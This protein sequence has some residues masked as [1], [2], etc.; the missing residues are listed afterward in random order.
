MEH[1]P[2][3]LRQLFEGALEPDELFTALMP[4]LGE[5]L[6]CDRSF[7]YLREPVKQHGIIT[8]CWAR[9]GRQRTGWVPMAGRYECTARS[10]HDDR[11]A[12]PYC[13]VCG[14]Y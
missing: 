11:P 7:L 6:P 3:G 9:D 12:Y 10:T 14:R 13:R 8:H 4:A 5:V 2:D 1:L